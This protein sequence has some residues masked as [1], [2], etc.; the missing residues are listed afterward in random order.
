MAT[1]L[2]SAI[3]GEGSGD[4]FGH[5][6]SLNTDGSIVAISAPNNEGDLTSV[7]SILG[8]ITNETNIYYQ[9]AGSIDWTTSAPTASDY[10]PAHLKK[11]INPG[12]VKVFQNN[13]SEWVQLG[14]E[15][16]GERLWDQ[17][18]ISLS[19]SGDGKTLAVGNPYSLNSSLNGNK[20]AVSVYSLVNNEWSRIANI[21]SDV[22]DNFGYTFLPYSYQLLDIILFI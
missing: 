14:N 4:S 10:L 16:K 22:F 6:V 9:T 15:I 2:N 11:G 7:S 12:S 18:G 20:P 17:K 19:L 3:S 21:N 13:G 8:T 1:I 5:A